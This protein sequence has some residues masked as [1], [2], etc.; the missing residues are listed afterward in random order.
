MSAGDAIIVL[1]FFFALEQVT[2]AKIFWEACIK[3]CQRNYVKREGCVWGGSLRVKLD[4]L[5]GELGL[6]WI[7]ESKQFSNKSHPC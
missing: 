6:C 7:L 3:S 4:C 1:Q 5:T 2:G